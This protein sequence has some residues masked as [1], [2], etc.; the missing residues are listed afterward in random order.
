[1]KSSIQNLFSVFFLFVL[2]K[3]LI[4]IV[5]LLLEYIFRGFCFDGVIA[6]MVCLYKK[7][8]TM[9]VTLIFQLLTLLPLNFSQRI[10]MNYV[11]SVLYGTNVLRDKILPFFCYWRYLEISK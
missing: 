9:S 1:M 11:D 8:T 5:T 10:F 2:L 3:W 6:F 4:C 7:S